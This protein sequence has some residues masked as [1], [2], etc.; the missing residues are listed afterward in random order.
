MFRYGWHGPNFGYEPPG[1]DWN[2]VMA[3][4]PAPIIPE[5]VYTPPPT[6]YEIPRSATKYRSILDTAPGIGYGGGGD[7]RFGRGGGY[8]YGG[9]SSTSSDDAGSR[10][11]DVCARRGCDCSLPKVCTDSG[12]DCSRTKVC[13]VRRGEKAHSCSREKVC[14]DRSCDC[15][16][17]KV[18][19]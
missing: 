3:P 17:R 16:L 6:Y 4:K 2:K 15:S 8:G 14:A 1:W 18:V 5:R 7:Y 19:L 10:S 12:C 11:Y 9:G 13:V